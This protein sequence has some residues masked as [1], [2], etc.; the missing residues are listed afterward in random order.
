M[1]NV[2]EFRRHAKECERRAGSTLDAESKARWTRMAERWRRCANLAES[3]AT[4]AVDVMSE[5]DR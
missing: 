1:D 3:E 5:R 4:A 2:A